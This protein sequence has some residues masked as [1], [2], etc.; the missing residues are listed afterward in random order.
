MTRKSLVAFRADSSARIGSGHLMRTLTLADELRRRNVETIFV[1]REHPGHLID[2][3]ESSGHAVRR[4]PPPVGEPKARGEY[5]QWLAV[6]W[7]VDAQE[8]AAALQGASPNWLVVDHYALGDEWQTAVRRCVGQVMV[9]DDLAD[10]RHN[11]EVLLDQGFYGEATAAR[12]DGLVPDRAKKLLGPRYALVAREFSEAREKRE[13]RDGTI[14]RVL[15]FFG[16]SD[17]TNE[18]VKVLQALSVPQLGELEVA[19]VLGSNHPDPESIRTR[20]AKRPRTELHENLE[21]LAQ[22]MSRADL[23]IGAGGT[24]TWERCTLGLPAISIPIAENQRGA[25]EA[26]AAAGVHATMARGIETTTDEWSA[27]ITA[28][29]RDPAAVRGMADRAARVTDGRGAQRVA[30]ILLGKAALDIKMRRVCR[31]DETMLLE[32]ANDPEV[33]AQSFTSAPIQPESHARWLSHK[34]QDPDTIFLIGEDEGGLPIGQVRFDI[35]RAQP[36]SEGQ[37]VISIS[38]DSAFR[39]CGFGDALLA[40]A[41]RELDK[42]EPRATPVALVRPENRKSRQL[43]SRLNFSESPD[44]RGGALVFEL[45]R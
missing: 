36:R 38:V 23:M 32:W 28:L 35:D 4:L 34:L 18:T 27:A 26:L 37:A 6:P 33:R 29:T 5:A 24:T 43:F 3:L 12:Y 17:S 19:V 20:V 31:A 41:L 39:G 1:S 11:A 10:R 40:A 21:T 2:R 16:G 45:R 25:T 9:I 44:R 22:A 7:E 8:T 13:A 14:R 15:I 30:R 42:A